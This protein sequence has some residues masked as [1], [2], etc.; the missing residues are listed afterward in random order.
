MFH[1][2]LCCDECCEEFSMFHTRLH[3]PPSPLGVPD[4]LVMHAPRAHTCP[5]SGTPRFAPRGQGG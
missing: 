1:T 4:R 2:R 3:P 5:V